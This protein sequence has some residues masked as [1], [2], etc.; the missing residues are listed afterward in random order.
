MTKDH[1][2]KTY[3]HTQ[4]ILFHHFLLLIEAT[5]HIFIYLLKHLCSII[6][7]KLAYIIVANLVAH[8]CKN[9]AN[10]RVPPD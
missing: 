8:S 4:I 7:F 2:I 10:G 6:I 9:Y 5:L 3:K 1:K